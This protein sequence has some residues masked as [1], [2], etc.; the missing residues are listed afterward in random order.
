MKDKKTLRIYAF[1]CPLI[2]IIHFLKY[3]H[4]GERCSKK[5]RDR[6]CQGQQLSPHMN[7][8]KVTKKHP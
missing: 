8:T 7:W 5:M 2:K 3:F 1:G 4:A 6:I